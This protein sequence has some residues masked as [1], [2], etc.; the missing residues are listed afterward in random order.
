MMKIWFYVFS[1]LMLFQIVDP[2]YITSNSL[3]IIQDLGSIVFIVWL[4]LLVAI[5]SDACRATNGEY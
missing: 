1:L 2:R 4:G 3:A 5:I